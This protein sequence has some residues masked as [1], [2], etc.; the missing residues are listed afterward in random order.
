MTKNNNNNN[1]EENLTSIADCRDRVLSTF[2]IARQV[3]SDC[4]PTAGSQ[5]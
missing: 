5:C 2:N 1:E 4:I 3:S